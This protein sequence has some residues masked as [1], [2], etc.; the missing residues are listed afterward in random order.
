MMFLDVRI[1]E[2]LFETDNIVA[3]DRDLSRKIN[4]IRS[5]NMIIVVGI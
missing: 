3:Y 1:I 4:N 5:D 2:L